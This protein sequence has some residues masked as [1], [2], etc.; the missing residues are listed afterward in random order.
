M[1]WKRPALM[2]SYTCADIAG[3]DLGD[4]RGCAAGAGFHR[5]LHTRVTR[6]DEESSG[7]GLGVAKTAGVC[8]FRTSYLQRRGREMG[9]T[10]SERLQR[11]FES[12]LRDC[13]LIYQ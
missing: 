6:S 8:F 1:V 13:K 10:D 4:G 7:R 9:F 3:G 11:D 5:K 2:Y 12:P